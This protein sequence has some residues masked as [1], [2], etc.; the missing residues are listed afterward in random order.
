MLKVVDFQLQRMPN[1]TSARQAS[2]SI[3]GQTEV[4]RVG[5]ARPGI[6]GKDWPIRDADVMAVCLLIQPLDQFSAAVD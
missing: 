6:A 4:L 1:A 5:G 2:N 3:N